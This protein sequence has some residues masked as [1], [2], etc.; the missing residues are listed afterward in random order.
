MKSKG[1]AAEPFAGACLRVGHEPT[2]DADVHVRRPQVI[3]QS[4]A[5]HNWTT[6]VAGF[7]NAVGP[8]RPVASAKSIDAASPLGSASG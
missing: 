1:K 2:G 3:P 5:Q 6:Q 7:Q 4:Q 8:E